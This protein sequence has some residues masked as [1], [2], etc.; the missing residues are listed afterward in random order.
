M[1][2]LYLYDVK[3][4]LVKN[5]EGTKITGEKRKYS[6]AAYDMPQALVLCR[7][8]EKDSREIVFRSAKAAR[9]IEILPHSHR[10]HPPTGPT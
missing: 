8:A 1:R 2:P 4:I 7:E 3:A 10:I 9:E 6:V 5:L